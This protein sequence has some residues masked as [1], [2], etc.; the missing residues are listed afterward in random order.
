MKRNDRKSIIS[1]NKTW[2]NSQRVDI[3]IKSGSAIPGT[4]GL[5]I[6]LSLH[7]VAQLRRSV[8]RKLEK[9]T[10]FPD[11]DSVIGKDEDQRLVKVIIHELVRDENYSLKKELRF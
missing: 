5:E 11:Q 4:R 10:F 6:S 7:D 8:I 1:R 3:C 2:V 9:V